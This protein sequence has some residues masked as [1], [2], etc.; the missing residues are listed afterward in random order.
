MSCLPCVQKNKPEMLQGQRAMEHMA[1]LNNA[2]RVHAQRAVALG[3]LQDI[4]TMARQVMAD[5]NTIT[6]E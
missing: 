3:Q 5:K 1:Q 4:I 6:I 2:R